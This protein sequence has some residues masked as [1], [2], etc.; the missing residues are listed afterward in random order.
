[1]IVGEYAFPTPSTAP[2]V[3]AEARGG[4]TAVRTTNPYHP[5][6]RRRV[7]G[8]LGDWALWIWRI[9]TAQYADFPVGVTE[10]MP[11]EARDLLDQV[12]YNFKILTIDY[13]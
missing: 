10:Q 8:V 9:G 4:H 7:A 1:M 3:P 5:D 11:V 6:F 12:G 2:P 13:N